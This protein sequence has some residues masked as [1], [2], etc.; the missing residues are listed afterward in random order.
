MER[1][2]PTNVDH[3]LFSPSFNCA[4]CSVAWNDGFSSHQTVT[5]C[6]GN[7]PKLY[8]ISPKGSIDRLAEAFRPVFCPKLLSLIPLEIYV[9]YSDLASL[10][11]RFIC[12]RHASPF[13]IIK[14]NFHLRFRRTSVRSASEAFSGSSMPMGGSISISAMAAAVTLRSTS[15]KRPPTRPRKR[16]SSVPRKTPSW[17]EFQRTPKPPLSWYANSLLSH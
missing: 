2:R 5:N 14:I 11:L 9:D 17:N 13:L 10:S 7:M 15:K 12:G 4:R 6:D 8:K 16:P 3:Q 1:S